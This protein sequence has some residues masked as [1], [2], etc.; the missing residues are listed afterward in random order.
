[1]HRTTDQ[2]WERYKALPEE[3][4]RLA[5]KCLKLLKENPHHP[6]LSLK[7]L[8]R[9]RSVRIGLAYRALA[10]ECGEDLIWVWIGNHD[11]YERIVGQR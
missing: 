9:F 10:V 4:R 1:M 2:F 11:D 3:V 7:K 5:D 8:G 6:S